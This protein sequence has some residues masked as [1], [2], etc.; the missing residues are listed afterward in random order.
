[1]CGFTAHFL[2]S[3][4][5]TRTPFRRLGLCSLTDIATLGFAISSMTSANVALADCFFV[6]LYTY[7]Y[8]FTIPVPLQVNWDQLILLQ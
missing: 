1:M 7:A 4:S 3:F 2:T 5:T 8:D 6:F